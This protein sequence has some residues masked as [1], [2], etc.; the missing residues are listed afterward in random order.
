MSS[1]EVNLFF[2]LN[3]AHTFNRT[4]GQASLPQ[5]KKLPLS[6]GWAHEMIRLTRQQFSST[7][8]ESLWFLG[9]WHNSSLHCLLLAGVDMVKLRLFKHTQCYGK[10]KVLY[11]GLPFFRMSS[12]YKEQINICRKKKPITYCKGHILFW[13]PLSGIVCPNL[14]VSLC[15]L[16]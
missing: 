5:S 11:L 12:L 7:F 1:L 14:K 3:V 15:L 2:F 8:W 16:A 13:A 4:P 6:T 10:E 9:N